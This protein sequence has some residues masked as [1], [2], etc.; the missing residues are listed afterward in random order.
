MQ[1]IIAANWK[2]Y[3]TR[4]QAAQC[5]EALADALRT[6]PANPAVLVFAPFTCLDVVAKA[7]AAIPALAA[8]AQDCYPADEGAFTG[9]ISPLM[10][11][12]AG[13]AWVLVGHS[14][15]RHVLGEDDALVARKTTFALE[16]GLS[17]MLCVGETLEEREAGALTAVLQR[18]LESV[19]DAL[20][21][22]RRD[23]L[24]GHFAVAYEPVWAIGTGRVAGHAEVLEA[25][26]LVR[27]LL[28]RCIGP[29]AERLPVLYGGSVKPANAA[30]LMGLDNVDGLLVGGASLDPQSFLQIVGA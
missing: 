18:Q 20:P 1:K 30:G 4:D 15:R 27:N 6:A 16:K 17:V 5:A 22:S 21:Q 11:R 14:E 23:A 29:A 8:G 26:A 10:L 28:A 12:D 13:A 3:K 19:F 7:F 2:M 25:H 24:E 9:E